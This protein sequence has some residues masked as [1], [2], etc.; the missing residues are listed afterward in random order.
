MILMDFDDQV[1]FCN[2]FWRNIDYNFMSFCIYI[3]Q[4]Q[5][6]FN[7]FLFF[8]PFQPCC[9]YKVCSYKNFWGGDQS[10]FLPF[11]VKI[12]K[13]PFLSLHLGALGQ[14]IYRCLIVS[15]G[16][17]PVTFSEWAYPFVIFLPIIDRY[18]RNRRRGSYS[19]FSWI[20]VGC[21]IRR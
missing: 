1:I 9:S 12:A 19:K 3:F 4:P 8:D 15:T 6:V 2:V 14:N 13:Q 5:N 7:L 18:L 10:L 21:V 17:I 11:F 20:Y 16:T